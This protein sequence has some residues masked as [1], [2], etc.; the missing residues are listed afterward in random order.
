M[1]S[2]LS[3]KK[4]KLNAKKFNQWYNQELQNNCNKFNRMPN[5][6]SKRIHIYNPTI[7]IFDEGLIYLDYS[8]PSN[9]CKYLYA[10]IKHLESVAEREFEPVEWAIQTKTLIGF[11]RFN[12]LRSSSSFFIIYYS[13]S[14]FKIE[15]K[16]EFLIFYLALSIHQECIRKEQYEIDRQ[17]NCNSITIWQLHL[18]ASWHKLYVTEKITVLFIPYFLFPYVQVLISKLV[19]ETFFSTRDHSKKSTY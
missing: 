9:E 17:W 3:E 10:E 12:F 1:V 7:I 13:K 15:A 19:F 8:T 6:V 16:V 11:H 14:S 4:D 2:Y 5:K 18:C